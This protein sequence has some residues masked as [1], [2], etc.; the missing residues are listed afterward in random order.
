MSKSTVI[1]QLY[2]QT[3]IIQYGQTMLQ[4]ESMIYQTMNVRLRDEKVRFIES[5]NFTPHVY[6]ISQNCTKNLLEHSSYISS[7]V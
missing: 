7:L 6:N 4:K 1:N 5:I 2:N 3:I